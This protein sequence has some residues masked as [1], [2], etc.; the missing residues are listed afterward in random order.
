M[1]FCLFVQIILI[2]YQC[3][4]HKFGQ[5]TYGFGNTISMQS[6]QYR[7]LDVPVLSGAAHAVLLCVSCVLIEVRNRLPVSRIL[8]SA[9]SFV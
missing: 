9:G 3:R 5:N 6:C 2:Q 1:F 4:E 7:L 8:L